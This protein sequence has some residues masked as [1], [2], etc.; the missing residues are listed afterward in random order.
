MLM[1]DLNSFM[2]SRPFHVMF[3]ELFNFTQFTNGKEIS[4]SSEAYQMRSF[5]GHWSDFHSVLQN[6]LSC[7][8][9]H[10]F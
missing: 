8:Y 5:P 7:D 10:K 6:P 1:P 3:K 2:Q 9:T 4:S